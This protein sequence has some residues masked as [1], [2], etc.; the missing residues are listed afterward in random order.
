M[1]CTTHCHI[2]EQLSAEIRQ[3]LG[4][5]ERSKKRILE[6]MLNHSTGGSVSDKQLDMDFFLIP[7]KIN[8]DESGRVSGIEVCNTQTNQTFQLTCRLLIYAVGFENFF[9]DG[10][11]K[12]PNG[13]LLMTDWCRV[14]SDSASVYA[15]GW[16]SH[17]A[18]GVIADSQQQA[19]SSADE[20]IK[21]WNC[22]NVRRKCSPSTKELLVSRNVPF[23]DW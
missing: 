3:N 21:D 13:Q 6:L 12:T 16:C 19:Y 11:P 9:L 2:S 18:R 23:I 1:D 5:V 20:I 14:P 8:I 15:T 22:G 17:A 10:L 7:T 4:T